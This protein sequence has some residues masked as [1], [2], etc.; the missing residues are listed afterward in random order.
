[1]QAM[2][3]VSKMTSYVYQF[4]I[5]SRV[6]KFVVKKGFFPQETA[7]HY[8]MRISQYFLERVSPADQIGCGGHVART[9][10][11]SFSPSEDNL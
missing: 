3:S 9:Q 8:V 11:N 5:T 2:K 10:A 7:V 1:M 4:S 6:T